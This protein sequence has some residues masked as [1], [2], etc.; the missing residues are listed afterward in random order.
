MAA[1]S[2]SSS[3]PSQSRR[4][5]QSDAV[6]D[7]PFDT[8]VSNKEFSQLSQFWKNWTALPYDLPGAGHSDEFVLLPSWF[9][10]P[11]QLEYL[12]T[13]DF[14]YRSLVTC[15]ENIERK[16][17]NPMPQRLFEELQKT[18]RHRLLYL[19]IAFSSS[20]RDLF[21]CERNHTRHQSEYQQDVHPYFCIFQ[22]YV[23]FFQKMLEM[24]KAP[25][26]KHP[27]R[28]TPVDTSERSMSLVFLRVAAGFQSQSH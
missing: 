9:P 16:L 3:S 4:L 25:Q 28:L 5:I 6:A 20:I 15:Y 8:N 21:R 1:S 22:R 14:S 26:L 10:A 2:S 24:D 12:Q 13:L 17:Q 27:L 18:Y 19:T 7:I 11:R 23:N